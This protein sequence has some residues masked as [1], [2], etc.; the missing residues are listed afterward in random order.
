MEIEPNSVQLT[1]GVIAL[2]VRNGSELLNEGL[3]ELFGL[4]LVA[5]DNVMAFKCLVDVELVV[6]VNGHT[7][8]ISHFLSGG[9]VAVA[10]GV[11]GREAGTVLAPF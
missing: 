5:R 6:E 7:E 1:S 4:V 8:E 9:V 10:R 3:S 11:E 2:K